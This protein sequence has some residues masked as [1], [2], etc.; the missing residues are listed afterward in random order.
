MT[1]SGGTS[2]AAK[3]PRL[4]DVDL[5]LSLDRETYE[6]RLL[7]GQRR[8]QLVQQAYLRTKD[9]AIIVFEGWDAAGKGGAIR[10]LGHALDP[11]SFKVWPIAAPRDYFK[12][13]HYLARFWEKLPPDGAIAVFDRSWYGR[14]LV[15]RVE[16]FAS[17][18]QWRRAYDEINCFEKFLVDDG[19]RL[20][21][22]FLHVSPET[23]SARFAAR[24]QDPAKRWK[25]SLDDFRN[26]ERRDAYATA[27]DEMLERT[28]TAETPWT[29]V[30][31]DSKRYARIAVIETI[32]GRLSA[33]VDL[34]PAP[35]DPEIAATAA[36][37]LGHAPDNV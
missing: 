10:R 6:A 34:A 35:L 11:R 24:M 29:V 23:Q 27:I 18:A 32:C 1:S 14:V 3:P 37:H 15:E 20:V 13:R 31:A 12:E 22:F 9:Q 26:L 2:A 33:G 8:L 4:A 19:A 25:L 16:A 21:K 36:K 7:A 5:S 17:E 28:H 30:A